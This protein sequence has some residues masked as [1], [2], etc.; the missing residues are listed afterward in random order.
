[1]SNTVGEPGAKLDRGDTCPHALDGEHHPAAEH[2]AEVRQIA[3][4][5]AARRVE[6]VQLPERRLVG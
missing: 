6:E 4:D 2:V 3:G 1:M 5:I